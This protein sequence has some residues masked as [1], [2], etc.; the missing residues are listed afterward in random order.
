MDEEPTYSSASSAVG[1]LKFTDDM[2]ETSVVRTDATVSSNYVH[3]DYN[4]RSGLTTF[5]ASERSK[6][7]S[8]VLSPAVA[9]TSSDDGTEKAA[10]DFVRYYV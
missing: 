7:V 5:A 2:F 1:Q 10:E 9:V 4:S 6:A 3:D 8:E